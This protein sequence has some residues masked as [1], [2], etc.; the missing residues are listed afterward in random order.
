MKS[1]GAYKSGRSATPLLACAALLLFGYPLGRAWASVMADKTA[2]QKV[3]VTGRPAARPA[4]FDFYLL[5]M[6]LHPAFCADGH[7]RKAECRARAGM[8]A[9]HGLWPESLRPGAYPRDCPGPR[10]AL[11]RP[12]AAELRPLMPGMADDLH[13]HEWRRHGTCSGL[14]DDEYFRHTLTLARRIDHALSSRLTSLSGRSV[15]AAELRRHVEQVAPGMADTLTFH[16]RTLRDAP[17]E[18]RGQA[19][20]VEIR[21]CVDDDGLRRA[22]GTA[23]RCQAVRRRDQGCGARFHIAR[24]RHP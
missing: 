11:G 9:I 22:P 18:H 23:L 6:T 24:M 12:L 5:A 21:Q 14:D 7:S 13:E 3:S 17:R 15:S 1:S 8:L 4:P 16:C 10:L 19:Y 2:Q 20:L